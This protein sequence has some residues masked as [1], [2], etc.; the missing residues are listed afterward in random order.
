MKLSNKSQIMH[1]KVTTM[2]PRLKTDNAANFDG[3]ENGIV[4]ERSDNIRK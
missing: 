4:Y 3:G 1:S 2:E